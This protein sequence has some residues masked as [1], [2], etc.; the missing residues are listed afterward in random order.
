MNL[1]A[2]IDVQ[3]RDLTAQW[4]AGTITRAEAVTAL[5]DVILG[6]ADRT[7]ILGIVGEF[8][9][10]ALDRAKE[11]R[12]ALPAAQDSLFPELPARLYIRPGVAKAVAL[13]T[14]HD[15]ETARAVLENRTKHA[16]EAAEADWAAFTA[17]YDKVRPLLYG[18]LTTS[19]VLGDIEGGAVAASP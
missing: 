13:F 18:E 11:P 15:W 7:L 5:R 10:R 8:A 17:A 4:Q 12:H 2:A 16:K 3:L 1:P 14:A 6:H 19:D 9:G